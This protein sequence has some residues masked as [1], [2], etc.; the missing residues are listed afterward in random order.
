M[1]ASA[2]QYVLHV[3][4]FPAPEED[5][6]VD[7]GEIHT[8][9]KQPTRSTPM[10]KRT[11]LPVIALSAITLGTISTALPAGASVPF[12]E[13]EDTPPVTQ[14]VQSTAASGG[15]GGG[16]TP[17]GGA[18]TGGG[19]LAEAPTS[20]PNVALWLATGG[21]GLALIG[22]GVA[23]RRRRLAPMALGSSASTRTTT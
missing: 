11:I 10:R 2:G 5:A 13:D 7:S 17:V 19:G 15:G 8:P 16:A 23:A 9:G 4:A 12:G 21:A 20:S 22:T 18:A 3:R 6:T 1:S 14:P